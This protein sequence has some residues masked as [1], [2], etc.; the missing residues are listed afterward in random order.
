MLNK[1]KSVA[2]IVWLIISCVVHI[3]LFKSKVNV[4]Y[5][6]HRPKL[7]GQHKNPYGR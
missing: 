4:D 2:S 6:V 7:C 5:Q 1:N 3:V